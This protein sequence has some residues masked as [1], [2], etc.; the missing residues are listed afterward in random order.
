[1]P[2]ISEARCKK[3]AIVGICKNAGKTTLLNAVLKH[4]NYRWGV[5]STGRDG[6]TEDV[7][8]KTPRPRVIIPAQSLFCCDAQ[9]LDAHG[10]KVSVLSQSKWH[11]GGKAVWIVKADLDLETEIIGPGNAEGQLQCAEQLMELGAQK[12]I[13]DGSLDRKSVV[14]AG[15]IDAIILSV[16]ASFGTVEAIAQEISRLLMLSEIELFDV[17]DTNSVGRTQLAPTGQQICFLQKG[18]WQQTGLHSLFGHEPQL[19]EW[20]DAHPE[21]IYIPGAYSTSANTRIGKHLKNIKLIFRHPECIKLTTPDLNSFLQTHTVQCLIPFCL[22]AIA[23]NSQGV[24]TTDID[25]DYLKRSM[26]SKF[27]DREFIDIMEL[28]HNE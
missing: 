5:L 16:G 8:F 4:H 1:M 13:I 15:G 28:V 25:A 11:S 6:E 2:W 10:A 19:H 22:K 3:I 14:L 26:Q 12:V 7:L 17:Q 27:P 9:S 24:G 21:A 18:Y 20:L 23:L